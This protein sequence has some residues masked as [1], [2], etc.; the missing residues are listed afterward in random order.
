[1]DGRKLTRR[2]GGKNYTPEQ[3]QEIVQTILDVLETGVSIKKACIHLGL[4]WST[5][6]EWIKKDDRLR[7]VFVMKQNE[8]LSIA[9]KNVGDE[10]KDGNIWVSQWFLERRHPD[11]KQKIETEN[12]NITLSVHAGEHLLSSFRALGTDAPLPSTDA[13]KRRGA[14]GSRVS[15]TSAKR[16]VRRKKREDT[17]VP[18]PV[19]QQ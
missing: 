11:F 15:A 19:Q 14:R 5:V 10:M 7:T 12:K 17:S 3:K 9:L 2:V 8:L 13:P 6:Y 1:M 4:P 16:H 18:P